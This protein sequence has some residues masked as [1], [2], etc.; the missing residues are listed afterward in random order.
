M[1]GACDAPAHSGFAVVPPECD[2]QEWKPVLPKIALSFLF[3][4]WRMVSSAN[5]FHGAG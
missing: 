4:T 5:R 3:L 2:P 1:A